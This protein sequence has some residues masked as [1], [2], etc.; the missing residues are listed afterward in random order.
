MGEAMNDIDLETTLHY[1]GYESKV[2]FSIEDNVYYGKLEDIRDLVTWECEFSDLAD[3]YS[4][5]AEAVED[6]L[7]FIKD[8]LAE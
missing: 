4:A 8:I 3:L 6:Y 2:Y 1:K 5:F 7:N